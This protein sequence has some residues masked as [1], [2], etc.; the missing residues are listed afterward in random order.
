MNT[1]CLLFLLF[2][3]PLYHYHKI[4][5]CVENEPETTKHFGLK[6][7]LQGN[8]NNDN[9][10]VNDEYSKH[11]MYAHSELQGYANDGFGVYGKFDFDLSEPVLDECNGHFGATGDSYD[12]EVTYHYHYRETTWDGESLFTPYW[13]GCQGPSKLLCASVEDTEYLDTNP[14]CGQGC[15]YELCVA[16][17]TSTQELEKYFE[18]MGD[19]NWADGYTINPY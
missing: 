10:K 12:G 11:A 18:K 2:V 3:G 9:D 4:S 13:V 6:S 17:G 19:K 8:N 16:T 14:Q 15:G 7:L 1:C 5:S